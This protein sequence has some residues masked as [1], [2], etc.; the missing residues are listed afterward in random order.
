M[1]TFLCASSLGWRAP[2][3]PPCLKWLA[4]TIASCWYNMLESETEDKKWTWSTHSSNQIKVIKFINFWE[5]MPVKHGWINSLSAWGL[6][7]WMV[8]VCCLDKPK[9]TALTVVLTSPRGVTLWLLETVLSL[10]SIGTTKRFPDGRYL[11]RRDA[12]PSCCIVHLNGFLIS[13]AI[14]L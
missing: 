12:C 1:Q 9:S 2:H 3:P 8:I 10:A 7:W 4:S 6:T 5:T 11:W 13:R 14:P